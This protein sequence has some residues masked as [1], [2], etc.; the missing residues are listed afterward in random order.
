MRESGQVTG[1]T[2]LAD[3]LAAIMA[4]TAAYCASRILVARY[5]GRVTEPDVD[6]VHVAMGGGMAYLLL[7]TPGSQLSRLGI[8]GFAVAAAYFLTRSLRQH[9]RPSY[10][11]SGSV[12][13]VQHALG[14]GAMIFMFLPAGHSTASAVSMPSMPSMPGMAAHAGLAPVAVAAG[15]LAALLLGFTLV[16]VGRLVSSTNLS[17]ASSSLRSLL[18][19]RLAVCC[20]ALMSMTMCY[21]LL[22]L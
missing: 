17:P 18:A 9:G 10:P 6:A 16:N 8:I 22:T 3:C 15:V 13:H 5:R 12:H 14:S 11:L 21:M 20:Q 19:P 1:P 2:W 4:I 7:R